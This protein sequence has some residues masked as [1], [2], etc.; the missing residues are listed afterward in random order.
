MIM[1][2]PVGLGSAALFPWILWFT[3][4]ARNLL[5]FENRI[6]TAEDTIIKAIKEARSWQEAKLLQQTPKGGHH[7]VSASEPHP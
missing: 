4:K 1:L 7:K 3:W 2:P 6:V 5:V